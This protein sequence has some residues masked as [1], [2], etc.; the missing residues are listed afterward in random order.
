VYWA[1]LPRRE[2]WDRTRAAN[3][4]EY[5]EMLL[6]DGLDA[7]EVEQVFVAIARRFDHEQLRPPPGSYVDLLLLGSST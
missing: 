5:V 2:L 3:T 1:A 4:P 6:G 7:T